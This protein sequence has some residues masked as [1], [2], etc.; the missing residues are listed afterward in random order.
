MRQLNR[1]EKC[2]L[3]IPAKG[4]MTPKLW[5][6]Q[7]RFSS[8][9]KTTQQTKIDNEFKRLQKT[10]P[11]F[12]WKSLV[13]AG[14]LPVF[15]LL[16]P[17]PF[18]PSLLNT[19]LVPLIPII[20]INR[21]KEINL[22]RAKFNINGDRNN[23]NAFLPYRSLL[24]EKARSD[25][26]AKR[27]LKEYDQWVDEILKKAEFYH[28]DSGFNLDKLV[29]K[30]IDPEKVDLWSLHPE[31]RRAILEKRVLKDELLKI[32]EMIHSMYSFDKRKAMMSKKQKEMQEKLKQVEDISLSQA[33]HK[34]S[35]FIHRLC[36]TS[37]D[38]STRVRAAAEMVEIYHKNP[39]LLKQLL[40]DP[41][42]HP[43]RFMLKQ[44]QA[45][46]TGGS[47]KPGLNLIELNKGAFWSSVGMSTIAQHESIHAASDIHF[48]V[49][50]VLPNMSV[51]Q[52]KA[53][54]VARATLIEQ[55]K[56]KDETLLG[57]LHYWLTAKTSTGIRNYAFWNNYEFLTVTLDTFKTKP[58][59]LMKTDAGQEIYKIY[60][61]IFKIDP[62]NDF[63]PPKTGYA[64]FLKK[65]FGK[66]PWLV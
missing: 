17:M 16:F 28:V 53:F 26:Q 64:V 7:P 5:I 4:A 50:S 40:N 43:L 65:L 2:Y 38:P 57:K 31:K 13:T 25:E 34:D 54:K 10:E 19:L 1:I 39:V 61:D 59:Q 32:F 30:V 58:A 6:E 60:K 9:V 46:M 52:K 66:E 20:Q 48:K 49:K 51:E 55:Y 3:P 14:A 12:R 33:I 29:S 37:D 18:M 21:G 36:S 62:A 42:G 15:G 63:P 44:D 8:L 47:Y 27:A 41:K 45:M 11:F 35:K 24:T 22:Q 23:L 56:Q